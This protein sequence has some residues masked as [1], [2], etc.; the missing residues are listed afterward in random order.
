M[1]L[2]S[3]TRTTANTAQRRFSSEVIV[4]N[5]RMAALGL[6][7]LALAG[8]STTTPVA[9]VRLVGKAFQDL[10]AASAPLLD[11][12]AFAE[13]AQGKTAASIRAKK[14]AN[15]NA[16]AATPT[17]RCS[18]VRQVTVSN[19]SVQNGFCLEDSYY[20]SELADPPATAAFRRSLDAIDSYTQ[21]LLILAE[22]RNIE[23]AQAEV[24]SIASN[25]GGVLDIAGGGVGTALT[26]LSS[27][28]QPLLGIAAQ[29][30]NSKELARNVKQ[31]S[32]QTIALIGELRKAAPELFKTLTERSIAR[33]NTQGLTNA[34]VAKVEAARIDAYR[35]A[36]SNYV[37]L[38]DEYQRLLT[39]LVES[40]DVEGRVT[41]SS[42]A[43]RSAEL[44]AQADVWRRTYSALRME[45]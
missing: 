42:L 38:L 12:L 24:Q 1:K 30:S 25:V 26:G 32:P 17:D 22:G 8:C 44:S 45:F 28:L 37:V 11:D 5:H 41:L 2:A 20:Y 9:E 33:M 7:V 18:D 13:R 43:L 3:D 39:N 19:V 16:G 14:H 35:T 27:A 34:E 36:V 31:V 29:R 15:P 23:A 21:V 4:F 10:N 40:Y 6:V